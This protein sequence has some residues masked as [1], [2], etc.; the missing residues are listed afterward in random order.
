MVVQS[1]EFKNPSLG[2]IRATTLEIDFEILQNSASE[3]RIIRA[4]K[5]HTQFT[6]ATEMVGFGSFCQCHKEINSKHI[7]EDSTNSLE[8]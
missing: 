5:P 8:V 2:N 6:L 7:F 3:E 1:N 4:E